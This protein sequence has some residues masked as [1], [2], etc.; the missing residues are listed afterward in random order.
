MKRMHDPGG[1]EGRHMRRSSVLAQGARA[2]EYYVSFFSSLTLAMQNAWPP[3]SF[4][5]AEEPKLTPIAFNDCMTQV[6]HP[7]FRPARR[8]Y[9]VKDC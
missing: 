9:S 5:D 6:F 7:L 2:R 3:P 1:Q 8:G 4:D